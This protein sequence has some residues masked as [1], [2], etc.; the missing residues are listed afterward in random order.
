MAKIPTPPMRLLALLSLFAA[1]AFSQTAQVTGTLSDQ[2]GAVVPGATVEALNIDT[3]VTRAST[4]NEVGNYLITALLPGN[5]RVTAQAPGFRQVVRESVRLAVDQVGRVDFTMEVG[6]TK[7]SITVEGS[8]VLLDAATST[9]GTVVRN[10]QVSE[11]PLAGRNPLDLLA[12]STGIRVQGGFG[13]K[14]GAWGNFSSNGGLAN[15]NS[16]MVEGLAL[17]MAQMNSPSFVPPVDATEE[18]RVQTNNFS[19]EFGRTAG[20]IVNFSIKSGTNDIHG[21]AY[22]FLRNDALNANNFFFNRGGVP[23]APLRQNQFGASVGGPIKRDRTF[24]F[25]N[26]E[27][28][29]PEFPF[30]PR[31]RG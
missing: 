18:F 17:D 1:C 31:R 9:V 21:S 26:W 10:T 5:Y 3:G 19:A 16:V 11:L 28:F 24:F 6:E 2:T 4:T 27:D 14:N 23:K 20:A 25:F 7:E 15:A 29:Y 12:L 8:A 22:E 30:W 13:G